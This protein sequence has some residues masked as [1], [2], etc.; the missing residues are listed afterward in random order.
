MADN[1][2]ETDLKQNTMKG[3]GTISKRVVMESQRKGR[4]LNLC[5]PRRQVQCTGEE[6]GNCGKRKVY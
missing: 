2:K 1:K 5:K 4:S 6:T 3:L